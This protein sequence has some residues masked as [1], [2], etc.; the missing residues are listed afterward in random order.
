MT[1]SN[2]SSM[3]L[4][5]E[6]GESLPEQGES[7]PDNE[8]DDGARHATEESGSVPA[9]A[10]SAS[11]SSGTGRRRSLRGVMT[12][13]VLPA[14]IIVLAAAAGYLSYVDSSARASRASAISSVQAATDGTIALLSYTPDTAEAKLTAARDLLT[15]SFRD[16]Y[17]ALTND[18]V[19]PGAIQKGISATAKVPAASTTSASADHAVVLVFVNQTVVVG[20][21]APSQTA[22]AVEVTMEKSGDRWLISGFDPK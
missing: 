15:G 6:D 3:T 14:L 7:S 17:T 5:Q 22:S 16:D 19:I 10:E 1:E 13:G 9:T 4:A 8:T 2:A 11:P 20:G 18:V 12:F 21:G